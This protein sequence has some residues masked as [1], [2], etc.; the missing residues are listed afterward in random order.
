[1]K[2]KRKLALTTAKTYTSLLDVWLTERL[3]ML[4]LTLIQ[5]GR[6]MCSATQP[7]EIPCVS[8]Q[9]SMSLAPRTPQ[10][11]LVNR[12]KKV[13]AKA[14]VENGR[15]RLETGEQTIVTKMI[16]SRIVINFESVF[17]HRLK[18]IEQLRSF[19]IVSHRC[20]SLHLNHPSS[21]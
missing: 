14:E 1:M 5:V 8:L 11:K 17:G 18:W 7:Y 16:L 15:W 2:S 12:G 20:F 9:S 10:V 13:R 19:V 6:R 4:A 21:S 3:K